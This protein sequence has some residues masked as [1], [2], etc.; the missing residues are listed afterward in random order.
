MS[1]LVFLATPT[2]TP[3][4]TNINTHQHTHIH[5]HTHTHTHTNK[6]NKQVQAMGS[7]CWPVLCKGIPGRNAKQ[8]YQ[9]WVRALEEIDK[10]RE[11]E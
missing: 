6:Q 10:D 7:S 2:P 8:C 9:R 4:H 3:T 1:S 11:R 5:T